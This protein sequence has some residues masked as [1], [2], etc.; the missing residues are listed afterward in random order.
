MNE[1]DLQFTSA[2]TQ[3]D[4]IAYYSSFVGSFSSWLGIAI[5]I[6]ASILVLRSA[7]KMG[8]GLFGT[9]LNLI[10]SGMVMVVLGTLSLYV[11][12]WFPAGYATLTQTVL[13]S[14]GYI[15]MVLGANKM[16][17]GIMS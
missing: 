1:N 6:I 11:S 17:K 4:P 10:G 12:S 3:V 8:G 9:V 16:L 15:L 13:F 7:H 2:P 5:G 14:L